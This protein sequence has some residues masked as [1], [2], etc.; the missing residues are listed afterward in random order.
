MGTKHLVVLGA[1][2]GGLTF[3]QT[4]NHPQARVTLVDRQ[5]HHLF[6]PLLYQVATAG[7]SAPEI[8]Q[9]IRSILS[10]RPNVTVLL[11]NAVGFNLVEK[12]ILL[13]KNTLTY[14]Y[15]VLALG[16]VTGYFGRPEWEQFAPGLKSLDDALRI[17]RRILL[18]FEKAE[19]ETN[20]AER[21]PL[22]TIVVVGGGPTGVELA[23]AFAELT[24]HV[25]RKDF[26]R[27]DPGKA[28][29]ILIEAG[30]RLLSHLT[31]GLSA[32]A[33]RQLEKLGV[34]VRT[35]TQVKNISRGKVELENGLIDAENIIWA[36]GV[37]ASPL[38]QK[39]GVELDRASRV[40]VKPDL[41]LPGHP[42]VFAIGDMALVLDEEGR[43]VPGVSPAAMQ[44]A[45]HVARII[46]DD[47]R[48][49]PAPA[50]R[51]PFKYWDKGT[52]ATIGRSAAVA[53]IGRLEFNGWLAW[54]AWLFVHL[55]FLIGFR[56]RLAV[57]LQWTYSYLAYKRGARIVTGL[58]DEARLKC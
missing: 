50:G 18:A 3:C 38:T 1:G 42:E 58:S 54:V 11:D 46:R 22:M 5:N 44:M 2:F 36:A 4:F 57:L 52:M 32:K 45:K 28:R 55:I 19:N 8:A 20:P 10:N 24:R 56:N 53:K 33:Q 26:R 39:L 6:Q 16:G 49:G 30:P 13:E 21:D 14:D 17:R 48:A 47:L 40:K 7:L 37:S 51:P 29:V 43:P 27:I 41:S 31:P 15:L 35:G 9:P 34:E 25:L 23:G 12:K